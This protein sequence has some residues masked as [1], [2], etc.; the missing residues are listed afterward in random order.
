MLKDFSRGQ[1]TAYIRAISEYNKKKKN[2]ELKTS[3][4]F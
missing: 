1:N 3:K 4:Q 2:R